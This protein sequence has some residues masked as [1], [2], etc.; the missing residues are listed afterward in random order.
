MGIRYR[1]GTSSRPSGGSPGQGQRRYDHLAKYGRGRIVD[2]VTGQYEWYD[3][4]QADEAGQEVEWRDILGQWRL[5][6]ADFTSEY[7][8]RLDVTSNDDLTW[9]VFRVH[10]QGL[11]YADTRLARHFAPEPEDVEV[12]L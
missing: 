3:T 7:R 12:P 10:L 2:E 5:I 8:I 1:P 6:V 9:V 4:S 11:M